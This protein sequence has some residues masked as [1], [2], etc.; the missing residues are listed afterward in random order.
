M[1][2]SENGDH[3]FMPQNGEI[4]IVL[5]VYQFWVGFMPIKKFGSFLAVF[6]RFSL[7][8]GTKLKVSL[9]QD[10]E[11]N[12]EKQSKLGDDGQSMGSH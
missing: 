6:C 10:Y 7:S 12:L 9:C 11:A 8:T 2:E 3:F 4:D 1:A 5:C